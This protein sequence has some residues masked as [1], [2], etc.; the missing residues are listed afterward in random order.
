MA[1]VPNRFATPGGL[2][3]EGRPHRCPIPQV[4]HPI[5]E[6]IQA[7]E[8][9]VHETVEI[10]P[11]RRRYLGRGQFGL[12]P[13]PLALQC[14]QGLTNARKVLRAAG[15]RIDEPRDPTARL[16]QPGPDGPGIG[17]CRLASLDE[18]SEPGTH[19]VGL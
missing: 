8:H 5:T 13:V 17:P 9:A 19:R 18:V 3:G 4:R 14:G 16:G 2:E 11:R 7:G 10:L 6:P 12:E 15:Q 1:G